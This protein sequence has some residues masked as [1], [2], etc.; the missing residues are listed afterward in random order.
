MTTPDDPDRLRRE[1]EQTQA[2]LSTDV[3]AVT[4]KVSPARVVERR[5]DRAKATAGRVRDAVLGS[6][7][8]GTAHDAAGGLAGTVSDSASG[9]AQAVQDAPQKA[10]QQARGNPVAAGL[11]AFGAGWLVSSLLPASRRE[12][13]LAEK[14]KEHASELGQPL[15]D[16]A[17]QAAEEIKDTMT[18]PVHQAVDAVRSTAQ[19]AG[20]AVADQG[21][22]A[23]EQVRGQATDSAET[24][25][26]STS[27]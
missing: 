21:R 5:V 11:I 8:A 26:R 27:G 4:D 9:A 14:A 13:V 17:K 20:Q 25:R 2:R 10:R 19:D 24:V 15:A 7:P 6:D 1:I 18:E 16:A 12:Q 22:S 23:A 3:N